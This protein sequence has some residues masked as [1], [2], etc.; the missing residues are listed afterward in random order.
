MKITK[1]QLADIFD[2]ASDFEGS[3][4]QAFDARNA[5]EAGTLEIEGYCK[6][7]DHEKDLIYALRNVKIKRI[8]TNEPEGWTYLIDDKRVVRNE[9]SIK[10][11]ASNESDCELVLSSLEEIKFQQKINNETK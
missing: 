8:K 11:E 3:N 9:I 2:D 5:L 10:I 7:D 1:Q 6:I 4:E